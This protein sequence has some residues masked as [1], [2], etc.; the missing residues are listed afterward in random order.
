MI[1]VE[2]FAIN[3]IAAP[4]LT[5]AQFYDL[6]AEIGVRKV[7]LRNDLGAG[8]IIDGLT[9]AEA[10]ALASSRGIEVISINALQKFNLASMRAKASG[11]LERLLELAAAIGCTSIV[12]CPNNDSA[13]ARSPALRAAET[14]GALVAFGPLFEKVGILGYIE[15]LGFAISSLASLVLAQEAIR[16]SGFSCYRVVHD[17][18][19]H[20]IGPEDQT[21][22][23][24]VYD[25]RNT[26]LVH[27]SGVEVDIPTIEY[28][29][30]HR[31]LAGP[32]DRMKSRE[33]MLRLDELGYSGDYSF[34]PFSPA[35]QRLGNKELV[36][37]FRKSLAYLC[38]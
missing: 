16:T 29:D 24:G 31:V 22:L 5:L 37:A 32:G 33:Q 20:Y 19:H 18:F 17:T 12:L 7:E 14:I 1:D 34:E 23:G 15:P 8:G 4:S 2:R 38:G 36:A 13:D 11:E 3:R 30:E 6:A 9:S 26:G 27:V 35:V 28:R 10:A 21:V 25:V